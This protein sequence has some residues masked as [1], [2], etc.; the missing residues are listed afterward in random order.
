MEKEID[1]YSGR[2]RERICAGFICRNATKWYSIGEE[3]GGGRGSAGNGSGETY[4]RDC[5]F[6]DVE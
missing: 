1:Y 2:R 5:L 6:I 3:V 4:L